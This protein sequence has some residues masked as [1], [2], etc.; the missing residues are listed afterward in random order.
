MASE[1][2]LP[3]C[4]SVTDTVWQRV[5]TPM[6]MPESSRS[7]GAALSARNLSKFTVFFQNIGRI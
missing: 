7:K 6:A 5:T 3:G 4:H 1:S 2:C